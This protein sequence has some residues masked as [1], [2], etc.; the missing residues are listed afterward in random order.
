MTYYIE[1]HTGPQTSIEG[2]T[3]EAPDLNT[4]MQYLRYYLAGALRSG[5][6]YQISSISSK[7]TRGVTYGAL[8]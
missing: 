2:Y 1:I 3:I 4:A 7:K 8:V 5:F 6:K